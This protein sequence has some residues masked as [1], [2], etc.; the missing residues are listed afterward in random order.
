MIGHSFDRMQGARVDP[1]RV[2]EDIRRLAVE[3]LGT[4]PAGLNRAV[5]QTLQASPGGPSYEEQN[6][7]T[8]LRQ[9]GAS[10]V[11]RFREQIARGFD[12]FRDPHLAGRAGELNLI[13]EHRLDF[14]LAGQRL[15]ET[16]EQRY[17]RPLELM[18]G[19]V[20]ALARALR[21]GPVTNPL[22]PAR[23]VEAFVNTY[24]DLRLP[25]TLADLVLRQYGLAL[26]RVLDDLYARVN[27]LLAG[28]SPATAGERPAAP[29][30]TPARPSAAPPA[31]SIQPED[32]AL[33]RASS[34]APY[35]H[36]ESAEAAAPMGVS[37]QLSSELA[38]LRAQLH[39]WRSQGQHEA[40][41]WF[42]GGPRRE[43]A[44]REVNTI[45]SILQSEAPDTYARALVEPG[46]L[47]E[48]IREQLT[49]GARRLGMSPDQIRLGEHEEDAIDMVAM[50]FESL[51]RTHS[52][53]DRAR[54]LYGRLVLPYVKVALAGDAMFVQPRHPA[55]RLLD[56]LTEACEYNDGASAHD[57]E[58]L[59]RA[60]AVSQRVVAEYNEDLA[61]FELAHAELEELLVQQRRRSELQ[62]SRAAK[63]TY[64]RERL[65]QARAHV[66]ALLNERLA[67]RPLTA[68]VAEFLTG[69]WRHHLVQG[70]LR[71]GMGSERTNETV[72]LGIAL[73]EA[74][75]L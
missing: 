63:A 5:E 21:A 41:A 61:V 66:D 64:G 12:G 75:A 54:R 9:Q 43:L 11:M 29:H 3:Q 52:L 4:L 20:D 67:A 39:A 19:R 57:R 32:R 22:G 24:G 44:T 16:L 40:R 69:P 6:A 55:R 28:M 30:A 37:P 42:A 70:L 14:H 25:G 1:G 35:G 46:R 73:V 65:A 71:D 31:P 33:P 13:D 2:I 48:T 38:R 15:A 50:L 10:H 23:L 53:Q 62:E 7:L 45:A 58:L 51:F 26:G 36:D 8:L 17:Q 49:S 47:G 34:H 60:S 59:E 74:D 68:A 72:A 27:A 18:D 56:A